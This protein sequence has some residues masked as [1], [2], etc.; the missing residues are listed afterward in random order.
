MTSDGGLILVRELD[1]RF[2]LSWLIGEHLVD[3]RTGCNR[4]FP[5]A[6]LLR[7]SVRSRLAD[8][9][10]LN[11]A[12]R[13]SAD[14]TFRLMGSEKVWERGVALTSTLH[15]FETDLLAREKNLTGLA[16]SIGNW[17]P[18]W[19]VSAHPTGWCWTWTTVRARSMGNR[20]RAPT[21]GISGQFAIIRYFYS[22]VRETVWRQSC[23]RAMCTVPTAGKGCYCRRLSDSSR[24][25]KR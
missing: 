7:Q 2:G 14:P 20:K 8:Y 3:S 18:R 16:G 4:Q 1:E 19:K 10:D 6:D 11:D 24:T 9:E 5:L 15:W 17:W 21:T 23:V 13:V 12:A 22:T 25:G